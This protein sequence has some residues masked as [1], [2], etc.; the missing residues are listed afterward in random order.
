MVHNNGNGE[1]E[2][3]RGKKCTSR[4]GHNEGPPPEKGKLMTVI[5]AAQVAAF[6][7]GSM[8]LVGAFSRDVGELLLVAA[9]LLRATLGAAATQTKQLTGAKATESSERA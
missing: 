1:K 9:A 3:K 5:Q 7:T 8:L 2:P 6:S 4:D